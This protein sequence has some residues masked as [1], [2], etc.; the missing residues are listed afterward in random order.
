MTASIRLQNKTA[1]LV[2]NITAKLCCT[3]RLN[4]GTLVTPKEIC[5]VLLCSQPDTVHKPLPYKTGIST[6]QSKVNFH[7]K[8]PKQDIT[9]TVA[10]CRYRAPLSPRLCGHLIISHICKKVKTESIA[11]FLYLWCATGELEHLKIYMPAQTKIIL[12][13]IPF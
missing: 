1:R 5:L 3:N 6:P 12:F 9:P 7:N 8:Y 4:L 13:I 11:R 2:L 10:D